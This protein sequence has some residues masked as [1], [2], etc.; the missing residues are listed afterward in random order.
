MTGTGIAGMDGACEMKNAANHLRAYVS[1]SELR[2]LPM[3]DEGQ[4][5]VAGLQN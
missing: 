1:A 2:V 4:Q 5:F 3:T